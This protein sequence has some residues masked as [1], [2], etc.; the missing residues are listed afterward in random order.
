MVVFGVPISAG[1]RE[2]AERSVRAALQML[3]RLQDLNRENAARAA[4]G[5]WRPP[6]RIGIGIHTGPLAA[7]N[8]GSPRRMEYSV[9]GETVNLAARLESATRGFADVDL[10]ISPATEALVRERFVTEPLGAAAAKGF[11]EM[12]EMY[13]VRGER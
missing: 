7:G 3:E 9:I 2:D 5:I 13:T 4:R 12:V 8:V 6:I 1:E 11:R 10:V